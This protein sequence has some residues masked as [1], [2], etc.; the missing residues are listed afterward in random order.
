MALITSCQASFQNVAEYEEDIASLQE[1]VRECYSRFQNP[2]NRSG[3]LFVK[4]ISHAQKWQRSSR[5]FNPPS[6]KIVV[7]SA[8]IFLLSQMS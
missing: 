6:L 7:K 4:K 2:R 5:I 8:W 1:N 3:S